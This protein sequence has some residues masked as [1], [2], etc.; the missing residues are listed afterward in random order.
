MPPS[1]CE[2]GKGHS[3]WTVTMVLIFYVISSGGFYVRVTWNQWNFLMKI[4]GLFLPVTIID[5]VEDW[6]TKTWLNLQG[7]CKVIGIGV[8]KILCWMKWVHQLEMTEEKYSE[9]LNHIMAENEWCDEAMAQANAIWGEMVWNTSVKTGTHSW[10]EKHWRNYRRVHM[11]L[12]W[13]W[14]IEWHHKNS[15]GFSIITECFYTIFTNLK[16]NF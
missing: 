16:G 14:N 11:L 1:S 6:V 7:C 12:G 13:S 8:N 5:N 2:L 4:V 3:S 9:L 15:E 10:P